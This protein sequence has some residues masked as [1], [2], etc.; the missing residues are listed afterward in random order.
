MTLI[1]LTAML[2]GP[3]RTTPARH[4]LE[5]LMAAWPDRAETGTQGCAYDGQ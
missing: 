2:G 3:Q 4:E 1:E 5:T